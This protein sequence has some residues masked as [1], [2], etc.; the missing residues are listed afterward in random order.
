MG[1]SK[2]KYAEK[3]VAAFA[4]NPKRYLAGHKVQTKHKALLE[5]YPDL[6]TT[7]LYIA[8]TLKGFAK[9]PGALKKAD[10]LLITSY[11]TE[12]QVIDN[13]VDDVN[14]FVEGLSDEDVETFE[15]NENIHIIGVYPNQNSPVQVLKLSTLLKNGYKGKFGRGHFFTVMF[16]NS[17]IRTQELKLAQKKAK[18]NA[19]KAKKAAS[20][21]VIKARLKRKSAKKI[22]DFEAKAQ[23]LAGKSALLNAEMQEFNQ[24]ASQFGL[25]GSYQQNASAIRMKMAN[26]DRTSE[27][28]VNNMTD[29]E[30]LIWNMVQDQLKAGNKRTATTMV[31]KANSKAITAL[32]KNEVKSSSDVLGARGAKLKAQGKQIRATVKKLRAR[33]VEREELREEAKISGDLAEYKRIGK[34]IAADKHRIGKY[35]TQLREIKARLGMVDSLASKEATAKALK[36]KAVLAAEVQAEIADLVAMGA[37]ERQALNLALQ[38]IDADDS[39]KQQIKNAAEQEIQQGIPVQVAA[40][41]AVQQLASDNVESDDD[42]ALKDTI[43]KWI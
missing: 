14:T 13:L 25:D 2:R 38:N 29:S 22:A 23:R 12:G 43:E 17:A 35:N 32:Y 6:L 10:N 34:N 33:I 24:I 41:Q 15:N 16:G 42:A 7:F 3:F 40:Q 27:A 18:V 39:L 31:K 37:S 8:S 26:M 20:P 30:V 19:R 4:K 5:E 9:G 1:M 11:H 36:S 21:N 28:L